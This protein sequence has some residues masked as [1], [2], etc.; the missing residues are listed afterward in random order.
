MSLNF[1]I[2][3]SF[4]ILII[5]STVGYGYLI[6]NMTKL[7]KANFSNGYIGLFGIFFLIFYSYFSHF[8]ISHNYINNVLILV[9]GLLFLGH[10]SF[11]LYQKTQLQESDNFGIVIAV[12]FIIFGIYD[13]YKYFKRI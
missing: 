9:L 2:F 1:A 7:K 10:G 12:G 8:F 5:T 6:V 11:R 3:V 4:Y 13:I